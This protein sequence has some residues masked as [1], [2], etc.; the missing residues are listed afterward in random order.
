[1]SSRVGTRRRRE[2]GLAY[3]LLAP[4][5]LLLAAVLGYPLGWEVWTSFTNLSPLQ[6]RVA[7]VGLQN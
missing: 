4:T 2:I 6:D 3:L 1:M 7:F 5:L